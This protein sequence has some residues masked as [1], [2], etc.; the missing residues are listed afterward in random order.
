MHPLL[1]ATLL[2]AMALTGCDRPGTVQTVTVSMTN[3]IAD[4]RFSMEKHITAAGMPDFFIFSDKG[5]NYECVFV[6]LGEHV[7]VLET[8]VI[9]HAEEPRR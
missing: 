9:V 7:V 5:H 3:V 1:F 4:S 6:T 2:A 8:N